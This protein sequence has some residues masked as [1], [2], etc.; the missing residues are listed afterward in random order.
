M[1][2]PNLD[3]LAAKHGG[4][5]G[6][7]DLD[8]LA[9]KHGGSVIDDSGGFSGQVT[10]AQSFLNLG[11][12]KGLTLG[13]GADSIAAGFRALGIATAEREP[14]TLG[15]N[16]L[17][18]AG[19]AIGVL[20]GMLFSA[21]QLAARGAGLLSAIGKTILGPF[22]KAPVAAV[23]TELAAGAGAGGGRAGAEA[24]D[25][26][27]LA[28]IFEIGGA[29]VGGVG[30]GVSIESRR[31]LF[32]TAQE[33]VRRSRS[34]FAQVAAP[35]TEA[36]ARPRARAQL[37]QRVPDP[38]AAGELV[39]REPIGGLSPAQRTGDDNLLALEQEVVRRDPRTVRAY[40]QQ[41]QRSEQT[42]REAATE[43]ADVGGMEARVIQATERADVRLNRLTPSQQAERASSIQHEEL[44]ASLQ[45]AK[46]TEKKLW[47]I[48]NI[49]VST[50]N[51][52]QKFASLEADLELAQ[53]D[54]MPAIARKLLAR[55]KAPSPEDALVVGEFG[56]TLV[57][58]EGAGTSAAFRDSES[59]R[60]V[61]SFFSKMRETARFARA[62][63]KR[64]E[65]RIADE[66]AD[67]AWVDLVGAAD[68]PTDVGSQLQA[69]RE[70]TR[71]LSQTF[72]RGEVGKLLG[73]AKTGERPVQP[74][75]TLEVAIGSRGGA[76]AGVTADELTRA[77]QFGGRDPSASQDAIQ[78][79]LKRRFLLAAHADPVKPGVFSARTANS[80][81]RNNE[82]L[83][84]RFPGL[85]QT[86]KEALT[87]MQ[88]AN[89]LQGLRSIVGQAMQ[90][91]TPK[92]S[93]RRALSGLTLG[94]TSAVRAG[95]L[96][97]GLYRGGRQTL[98]DSGQA[99]IQGA[100]LQGLLK[101]PKTRGA[102]EEVFEPTQLRR[103]TQIADELAKLQK[104]VDPT[105][106]GG[107][108]LEPPG[109]GRIVKFINFLMG[110]VGARLG[111][112]LGSGTSGASLRTASKTARL[113]ETGA[114]EFINRRATKLV[115]D[116]ITDPKL[117]RD[118][119]TPVDSP[120]SGAAIEGILAWVR[121][122]ATEAAQQ[123]TVPTAVGAVGVGVSGLDRA[124]F[125]PGGYILER[126]VAPR[127]TPQTPEET[128][129]Q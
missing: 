111:S 62:A 13:A 2:T 66:L 92:N 124:P 67:A 84:G 48:P 55:R 24:I 17:E 61:H 51:L 28:P 45:A 117:F 87:S 85:K 42:L 65:A 49:R 63:G 27:E 35:F 5:S 37:Q 68:T 11:I 34:I 39:G 105:I 96:E 60:A 25:R 106:P 22:F 54:D 80:F 36:G 89:K 7:V 125:D 120:R 81:L 83:L 76:Q 15:E 126:G 70:Y 104:T 8:A 29:M 20:P 40:R 75:E 118:L 50:E 97:Y 30:V 57:A 41:L 26:P 12:A 98:D 32:K 58:K 91:Q 21:E 101:N 73:F 74:T 79:F 121:R 123:I 112:R 14:E 90:S 110:T 94:D 3:A 64:N 88:S 38:R 10:R 78:D 109:M 129:A 86:M 82:Q 59:V 72:R 108:I 93:L 33:T 71:E 115:E 52:R 9:K 99:A 23:A 103:L 1:G 113:A 114:V 53:A 56:D 102:F 127:I 128:L 95:M 116:A 119:L 122:T 77:S 47:D 6:V 18:G 44:L 100:W 16:V 43:L 31:T 19:I 4:I 107:E 69:A 46:A